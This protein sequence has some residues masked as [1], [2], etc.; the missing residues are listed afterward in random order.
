M[1][2]LSAT[3]ARR[4][5]TTAGAQ[6]VVKVLNLLELFVQGSPEMTVA[7]VSAALKMPKPTAHR[8][9]SVLCERGY[10]RQGHAGGPYGLGPRVLALSSAYSA[11]QPISRIALPHLEVLRKKLDETVGLYVRVNNN[12]RILIERLQS[13]HAM[14]IVMSR[15]VPMPLNV[16]AGGRVLASDPEQA[17]RA[18]VIVTREERVPNACGIAAAVFDHE[19]LIVAAIDVAG[20]LERF[21]PAAV[22]RYSAEVSRTASAISKALGYR[23]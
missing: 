22:K 11:S 10:L 2:T 17:R 23:A 1:P 14:Q 4:K 16:G 12:S 5:H 20:P 8:L 13:S 3:R 21:T 6:S 19:G 9:L 7:E 15:G 18:G